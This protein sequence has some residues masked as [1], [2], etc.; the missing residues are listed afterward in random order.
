MTDTLNTTAP[1]TPADVAGA[2]LDAIEAHPG[3][4]SMRAW[5]WLPD[6]A[7]LPPNVA[8]PSGSTLCAAAWASHLT[9]WTLIDGTTLVKVTS[10][11][12]SDVPY[13]GYAYNYA[14]KN[15]EARDIASVADDAPG[16]EPGHGL[17]NGDEDAAIERLRQIA[18]R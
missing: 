1:G 17:W 9:G 4:F 7:P 12:K 10:R 11:L 15:G 14:L 18:G 2:V 13:E 16:L 6:G 5:C 8:P 3:A